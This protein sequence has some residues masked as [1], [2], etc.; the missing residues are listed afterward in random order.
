M[1]KI[2]IVSLLILMGQTTR[3]QN[4]F[5]AEKIAETIMKTYPD[6]MVV[7]KYMSHLETEKGIDAKA[8]N[9]ETQLRNR[10]A[11]WNYEIGV[12]SLGF[13]RLWKATGDFKYYQYIK[14]IVDKFITEDGDIKTYK[15]SDYNS[16]N[17]P[18]GR[19]LLT[20][21]QT[22]N[23]AKYK[24]AAEKLKNQI[25]WMPRNASGGYWH[26]LIYPTQMWLDGLY[27]IEP[28]HA[29]LAQMTNDEHAFSEIT[30]QF[31]LME[32][33][34]KD[35]KTC[36]LY[37]GWD[38]SK[39]QLW[40]NKETGQSPNFWTR[41]MGWY[42]MGLVDVLDYY[43]E[44]HPDR[45]VLTAILNRLGMSLLKYQDPKTGTWWQVTNMG[46]KEG[47]YLESSGSSMVVYA[48]A[49]GVKMGYLPK[50][51]MPNVKKTFKGIISEFIV[52]KDGL[53]HLTK[54]VGGAG[55]GGNPYRDGSYEYY[56]K[57][58]TRVDDLKALG[59]FMQA[60][61]EMDLLNDL[62][63]GT[64][65]MVT[66]DNFFNNE[67]K[68]GQ[69][70]HYLWNDRFDSGFSWLG[71][72]FNDFGAKTNT[73]TQAPNPINLKNTDIYIIVDP[74]SKKEN[75]NPN[76][77]QAKDIEN[78]KTW[79]KNGGK[80]V[81]LTNDTTN[82]DIVHANKLAEAFGISFTNKNINFVKNDQF[83][84]GDIMLSGNDPVLG[85]AKKIFIKELVTLALK[86][87][88]KA[89]LLSENDIIMASSQYGKG[90]VFVLGDPWI[91]N[92]YLNGRKLPDDFDN[93]EAAKAWA[94]WLLIKN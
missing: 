7:M 75:K 16:D 67:Y 35:P 10:P 33:K 8:T 88:A 39:M 29:N 47:N 38:E 64:G 82:C 32:K 68:N 57:E 59:P 37:H 72:I 81:L 48:L 83:A 20:F 9:I 73:L 42:M 3:A 58:P 60:C 43:P 53:V 22:Q 4:I 52:E 45:K 77:I 50:S 93:Y 17:I 40:A 24:K 36:L 12:V 18:T 91:Y 55:L 49:K 46:G 63:V 44:N 76:Y 41:A 65:K 80:L 90:S 30:A 66:L 27:M 69:K 85:N 11:N 87:P 62:E 54:G 19:Q 92:E 25:D 70:F 61:I 28:F 79:V 2:F 23:I 14:K 5:Y 15:Q 84:Q 1:K 13:E 94:K 71:G 89:V 56:V 74:D 78:L 86:A 26:K 51:I 21:Y 34:A 6:S 31:V